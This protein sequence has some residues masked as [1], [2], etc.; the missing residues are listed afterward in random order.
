[1]DPVTICVEFG[2]KAKQTISALCPRNVVRH[3]PSL[4]FHNF[5]VWSNEPVPT[6]SAYGK[7]NE[8]EYTTFLWPFNFWRISPESVSHI[9]QVWSYEPVMNLSPFL[10]KAQ[11]VKGNS[12]QWRVF[13]K[14][15]FLFCFCDV[16]W[17]NSRK[18]FIIY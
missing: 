3:L 13:I 12:W 18:I 4:T 6:L 14:L 17:I 11:F 10:L 7:L 15:N 16:T 8:I 5:A 2:S 9:I 1:M